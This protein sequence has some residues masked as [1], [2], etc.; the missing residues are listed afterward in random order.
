MPTLFYTFI[1]LQ[2]SGAIGMSLIFL[3]VVFSPLVKRCSTWYT[4][5]VSWILSCFSYSLLF[6]VGGRDLDPVPNQSLCI[7]QAALIYSVPTLTALTTLSLLVHSWY[8]VHFGISRPPLEANYKTIVALL[9]APYIIWFFMFLGFLLFSLAQSSLV[10]R[11]SNSSYC[12]I[13]SAIPSKISSLFV[14]TVTSSMLPVQVSLGL[15]LC[16]NLYD[17]DSTSTISIPT[18]QVVI[19]VMIFSFLTLVAFAEGVIY[20]FDL[21][22]GPFVDIIMAWL[23]VFGVLIFGMQKDIFRTWSLWTIRLLKSPK[24]PC[25]KDPT[26]SLTFDNSARSN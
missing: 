13:A 7:T 8:N 15:S 6:L 5:C 18:L 9:V 26:P 23:P 12:I 22:P 24:K 16:R 2:L 19:R 4:F 10:N 20:I 14:V 21:S 3:T 1:G 11:P 17:N 25:R